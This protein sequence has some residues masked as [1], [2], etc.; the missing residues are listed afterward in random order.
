AN[1]P[2]AQAGPPLGTTV[3][4]QTGGAPPTPTL[5]ARMAGLRM[6]VTHLYGLTE[7]FGPIA[8]NQ[9]QPQWDELSPED[10]A[11]R[12]A[13]QGVGNVIAE[14]L[15]VVDETGADVPADGE[16]MGEI[17]VRGNDVMLG[18]YRDEQA[19][20][21][22]DLKGWLRTGDLAVRHP[23]GYLE[24]RD[25]SKDVIISGGENIAS[26]EVERVID[27][28]PSVLESAVVGFPD[29]KW[30]QVPVAFVSLRKDAAPVTAEEIVSYVR[31]RLAH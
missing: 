10:R 19:T 8:V 26:V 12:K 5:L 27:S 17:V 4:V 7:T 2:E 20:A 1:A 16:T 25:R 28:H 6:E 11:A 29:D 30:G 31:E 3:R 18:Y 13:R 14:R 15:R 24:I 21:E 9:W 22:V 23:D